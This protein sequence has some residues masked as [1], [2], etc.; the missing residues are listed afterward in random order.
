MISISLNFN[1]FLKNLLLVILIFS[2]RTGFANSENIKPKQISL[3]VSYF[4]AVTK[5]LIIDETFPND[6]KDKLKNWFNN[7]VKV[8]GVEGKMIF[9]A[10]DYI[11]K[12]TNIADG[13]KVEISFDFQVILEKP[14]LSQ[15]KQIRGKVNSFGSLTGT[16]SL[17]EFDEIISNTQ[18]DVIS[19]LSTELKSVN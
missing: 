3:E 12:I 11:Q 5:S 6:F 9:Y 4:D 8:N 1:N 19:R 10:S 7:R 14:T 18:F 17:N 2:I 15:K 16:F 13:K